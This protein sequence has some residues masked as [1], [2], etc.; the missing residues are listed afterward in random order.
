V[1]VIGAGGLGAP[2][3]MYLAAAGVGAL[4]VVDDDVVSLSNPQR[5]V[6]HGTPDIGRRKVDTSAERIPALNPHVQFAAHATAGFATRDAVP[7]MSGSQPVLFVFAAGND[8][9][10][11]NDG[12]EGTGDSILSPGTAKNVITVGALEQLRYITNIVTTI[13]PGVGTNSP[14]TNQVAY[15]QAWTDSTN[16]LAWYSARGNVGIG[17]EG[18]YGRFKPDLVSPGTFVVS[19]RSSQW[20]TNSYYNPTN[21]LETD[22][23]YQIVDTNGLAYYSVAV[24]A[25]AVEVDIIISANKY[26]P[27]PFPTL[28]LYVRQSSFPTNS[29]GGYDILKQNNKLSIPPDSGGAIAGIQTIQSRG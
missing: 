15:W 29:P 24:P 4:G 1:L 16:Q 28:P 8:G 11:D 13:T 2:A 25:N 3:L 27:V 23:K 9:G 6:I 12:V 18:A 17:D 20:D 19:T 22:Y 7:G 5:Q 14:T 21:I 10:G 26:S